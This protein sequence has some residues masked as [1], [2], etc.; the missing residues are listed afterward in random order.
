M[1]KPEQIIKVSELKNMA[2]ILAEKAIEQNGAYYCEI[3][4]KLTKVIS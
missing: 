1:K 3:S 2:R 4:G